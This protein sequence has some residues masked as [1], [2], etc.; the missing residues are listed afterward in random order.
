VFLGFDSLRPLPSDYG[1]AV[2]EHGLQTA[3]CALLSVRAQRT[4]RLRSD[5]RVHVRPQALWNTPSTN[6][7]EFFHDPNGRLQS[8]WNLWVE[9]NPSSSSVSAFSVLMRLNTEVF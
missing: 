9:K 3:C 4:C 2:R 6:V 8:Y 5:Q 1:L 7:T